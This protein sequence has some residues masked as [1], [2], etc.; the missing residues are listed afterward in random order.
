M[1][2]KVRSVIDF[3]PLF[4]QFLEMGQFDCRHLRKP[5][6]EG[7]QKLCTAEVLTSLV[8]RNQVFEVFT[9]K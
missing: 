6:C 9:D 5:A 7:S 4:N 2:V 8:F 1:L 3:L